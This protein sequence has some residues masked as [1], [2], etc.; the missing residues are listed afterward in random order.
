MQLQNVS[1][2]NLNRQKMS[3]PK[4]FSGE[5]N[6]VFIAFQQ[7]HQNLINEWVPLAEELEKNISGFHY[8]E[9]PV[10]YEMGWLKRTFLNEGMRAGIPNP[11]TRGR[12][13]TLYLDKEPFRESLDI[14]DESTIWVY[15]F[16]KEGRVLWRISGGF[17]QEKGAA[18][19]T[20][21]TE[22]LEPLPA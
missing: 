6:L 7:W 18:L 13:I 17:S 9:F 15:L 10:V 22:I 3:F 16:D 2:S 20:A 5:V 14:P 19:K 12:T 8:Y 11:A 1:G 4:D 21:V